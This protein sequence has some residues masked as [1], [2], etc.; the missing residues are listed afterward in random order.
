MLL[1][2]WLMALAVPCLSQESHIGDLTGDASRGKKLYR[3]YCVG[4][5]G[6]RGD[7]QGENAPWITPQPRDF[8]AGLFKCRSTP[9]GSIPRDEDIFNSITRGYVTTNMPSWQALTQKQR[10]DL[11]AYIKT[12]SPRFKEERPEQ[13]VRITPETP[14]TPES[15]AKGNQLFQQMKC[16]ECHG[17]QGRGDG[18]S[19]S[20]LRDNKG[21]PIPPYDFSTGERFKCGVSNEDLERIFLTGLDGTPMPSFA[22]YLDPNQAWDLVHFLRTLQ[23][24]YHGN[25]V[26]A[27]TAPAPA[28]QPATA[29]APRNKP[30]R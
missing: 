19:A 1:L 25:K 14:D 13:P 15:V 10:A 12:F 22:D 5:H 29:P 18:P 6:P 9:S 2:G 23:L 26:M 21:N 28:S 24:N 30:Q 11:V 4:C 27:S 16:W 7:S 3:R 8:T 20:T 17:Q